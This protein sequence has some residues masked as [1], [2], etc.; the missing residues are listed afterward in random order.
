MIKGPEKI[1][2]K[3]TFISTGKDT[4]I[5]TYIHTYPAL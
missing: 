2:I 4:C 1:E 5:H 3:G